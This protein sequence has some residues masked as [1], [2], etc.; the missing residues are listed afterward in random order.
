MF[1]RQVCARKGCGTGVKTFSTSAMRSARQKDH[2]E[3]LSVQR[4]ATKQQVKAK[5]YE[6]SKKYH[7]DA[8]EGDVARF[9]EINDAYS[10]LGDE[11]KR[12]QYDQSSST[13]SS[14]RPFQSQSYANGHGHSSF[15]PHDPH[16]H[17]AAQGPHRSWNSSSYAHHPFS[18]PRTETYSPFGRR[19]PEGYAY[20]H[21][22]NYSFNPNLR[23]T[24]R[25]NQ[26]WGRRKPTHAQSKEEHVHS[27]GGG[28]WRF[29]ITVGM[30]LTVISLGG[31]LT[32]TESK[33]D[34]NK[35]WSER[36]GKKMGRERKRLK[37]K[38]A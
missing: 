37:E 2:Y 27:S 16:L 32:A 21:Q 11:S 18:K 8:S 10:I 4:N 19:T 30:I 24:E 12:R 13:V 5:F 17:R 23:T 20:A 38:L 29:V 14:H 15:R 33:V 26:G 31:G 6:L 36:E 25:T 1:R 22:Y 34:W 28:I 35:V 9:H 7:P 3:T